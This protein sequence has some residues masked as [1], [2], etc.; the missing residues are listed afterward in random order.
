MIDLPYLADDYVIEFNRMFCQYGGKDCLTFSIPYP[1]IIMDNTTIE[2]YFA[3]E[4]DVEDKIIQEIKGADSSI[5]FMTFAFT[6]DSIEEVLIEKYNDGVDVKGI[7]EARQI[8]AYSAYDS[9]LE[10]GI[11][12]IKDGNSYTMH[13][14]V[15]IIDNSTVI[16]GSYNPTEHAHKD[17]N[18]NVL[19][20][21]DPQITQYYYEEFHRLWVGWS[22]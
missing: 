5:Y 11:G 10:S 21:H 2:C 16:T 8:N 20:I 1:I 14:K 12:A 3:P 6:S 9:L 22:E 7:F 19:I 17:N 13:H 4:D 18:E 15:F